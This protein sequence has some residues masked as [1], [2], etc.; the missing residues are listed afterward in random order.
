MSYDILL[1]KRPCFVQAI[2]SLIFS[3]I[4]STSS[5]EK[6]TIIIQIQ[7]IK[8]AQKRHLIEK[9]VTNLHLFLSTRIY[10]KLNLIQTNARFNASSAIFCAF[11]VQI[12]LEKKLKNN[13]INKSPLFIR[14]IISYLS[15]LVEDRL[16]Y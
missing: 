5:S 3:T 13:R 16:Q 6:Q 2:A 15:L 1:N 7:L 9:Y 12:Q 8:H 10:K 11:C 4:Y 14:L